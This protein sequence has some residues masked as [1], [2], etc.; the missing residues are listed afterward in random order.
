[1]NSVCVRYYLACAASKVGR[2]LLVLMFHSPG[3]ILLK[4]GPLTIRWYGLMIAIGFLLA[5]T[6]LVRLSDRFQLNSEKMINC[7]LTTFLG[8]V[9]GARLYYVLLCWNHFQHH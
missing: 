8:G 9:I 3:E 2:V 6:V 4:L 7:A 1:M 5:S